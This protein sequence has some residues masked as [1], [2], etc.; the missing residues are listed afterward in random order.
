LKIFFKIFFLDSK[1]N[2]NHKKPT[3]CTIVEKRETTG[4]QRN[5]KLGQVTKVNKFATFPPQ[6]TNSFLFVVRLVRH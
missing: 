1:K 2:K 6:K 5:S 4:E 3:M